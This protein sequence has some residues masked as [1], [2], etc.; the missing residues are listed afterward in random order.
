[1]DMEFPR[2]KGDPSGKIMDI[3]WNYTLSA[4]KFFIV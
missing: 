3:F 2:G 4:S 1:M